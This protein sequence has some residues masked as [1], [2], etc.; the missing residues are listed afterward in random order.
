MTRITGE[1]IVDDIALFAKQYRRFLRSLELVA[2]RIPRGL[3]WP[4]AMLI[5]RFTNPYNPSAADITASIGTALSLDPQSA[6]RVWL[7]WRASHTRFALTIFR[8]GQL[9]SVWLQQDVQVQNRELLGQI[10][11]GGGLVLG[12]H[13]HHHNTLAVVLGEAGGVLTPIA[14]SAT[15]SPLYRAIGRYIDLINNGSQQHLRGGSYLYTDNPRHMLQEAR[16]K[17]QQGGLLLTLCDFHQPSTDQPHCFLGRA[18]VPPTGVI[19]LAL[20]CGAPIYYALFFPDAAG[21]L[22]LQLLRAKG[23]DQRAVVDDYLDFLEQGVRRTPEAWQGWEWYSRL[24]LALPAEE[25]STP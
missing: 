5:S 17:L 1:L 13:T 12:Y 14:A 19:R 6:H 25:A 10:V 16:A 21:R 23:S 4:L 24:P 18:I 7:R 3:Q 8:Y 15:D 9:D 2:T 20:Q 22:Q 11:T